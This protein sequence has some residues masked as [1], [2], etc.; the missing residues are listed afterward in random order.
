MV[1]YLFV[2]SK[3]SIL[4]VSGPIFHYIDI[5]DQVEEDSLNPSL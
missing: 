2:R 5:V 4:F 1:P 3:F